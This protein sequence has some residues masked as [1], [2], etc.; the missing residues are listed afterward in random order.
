MQLITFPNGIQIVWDGKK[1][2]G[3][4]MPKS[5]KGILCGLCGEIDD[6]NMYIGHHSMTGHV[7][8]CYPKAAG[9]DQNSVVSPPLLHP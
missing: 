2:V 9:G 6:S 5:F 8:I 3:I 1:H 7:Y 4:H